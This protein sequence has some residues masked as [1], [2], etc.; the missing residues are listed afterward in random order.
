MGK[1]TKVILGAIGVVILL[2][3]I[4]A[5]AIPVFLNADAFRTRMEAT[6]SKSLGR[7]VTIGKLTL[8]VLSGGMLAENAT[9]ADD[10]RFSAAPFI[11]ASSV[12]IRV[13]V[14]PL[15]LNREVHI[16]G[17]A[18]QSPNV[19]LVRG[20]TG[21][22]N[23]SSIGAA[24]STASQDPETQKTF[25]SLTVGN[26]D[27]E[28]GR[29][30]V[31][32]QA[33]PGQ[34][35]SA[36]V[37]VYEQ[38]KITASNFGFTNSFPF[39]VSAQLP[40]GGTVDVRGTA[41]PLNQRDASA[42][43]FSGHLEM[44][45]I[46]PLAAGFVSQADGISGTVDSLVLD[47]AWNGQQMQVTKL[48][49]D[50]PHLTLVRSNAPK[51][52]KP[53]E[54]NAEGSTMLQALSINSAEVKNGT[55]TLTTAGQAGAPAVYQ[56]LNATITNVSPKSSSPFTVSA[57]L[58]GGGSMNA[59][60]KAGPFNQQNNA[61]TPVSANVKLQHVALETSGVIAPDAG[62]SGLADL[63]AQ[64]ESN[65]Q[66]LNAT[67][68]AHVANIKLARNGQPSAKPV[69]SQFAIIQN[70]Q[71]SSGQIEHATISVGRA[72]FN[73]AG[74]Y[75]GSGP[76]TAIDL[77]V[78]GQ[79]VPIDEIEAF[80]PALGVRL[81]Q[82]SRLQG[83]TVTTS[84]TVSGTTAS[85]VIAGPVRLDNTQLAGFNLGAKLQ[86]LSRLTGGRIGNSTGNGTNIR[87][88][89]MNVR[90][91]GGGIRTDNIALNV[92]GVGT[93]TGGGSVSEAGALN[94]S[95][96]LKL[97]ELTGAPGA[98]SSA[99]AAP[100]D[101]GAGGLAGLA[102]N[103][104]GL[105]P[106]GAGGNLKGLGAVGGIAGSLAKS[107]IPVE[108]G[109]TTSNPTFAPNLRG[110]TTGIGAAAAQN[111]INGKTGKKGS[112][113]APDGKVVGDQIKS[114]KGLFGR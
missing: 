46:D 59:S 27:V 7:K 90:E 37:R 75:R 107:G 43:P 102:G 22:W 72:A 101:T 97:T 57:Q 11:Q 69:E 98:A 47:A 8:S 78:N 105:I 9:V 30:S 19:Q 2:A 92:A 33:A 10:P 111:L 68:T 106:G 48:V 114:L 65:G 16:V 12:K 71:A 86:S 82:G 5:A 83:G 36:P 95:V 85:P 49:V 67:G 51:V 38:V 17:F 31:T 45:H 39:T 50:T 103:L 32:T 23:Y 81:P 64:I 94:Y 104:S 113:T 35:V 58:P 61:S 54:T 1:V 40:A 6:L 25:P 44:K 56:Q 109:G 88:L 53:V 55:V 74:G 112:P 24:G 108:I 3:L 4:A 42:T 62:I 29:V 18:L 93:A 87:S 110:L 91:Q 96:L 14:L 34:A 76:T 84:L 99:S 80:L 13:E 41:G 60:G 63:Q 20:A 21:T 73:L 52:P 66:T 100:A 79:A 15:L 77:R 26:F 28:N 70:E 89:V